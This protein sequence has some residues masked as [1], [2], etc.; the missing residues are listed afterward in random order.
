MRF[1]LYKDHAGDWRWRLRTT[2]GD[3]I[4]DSAE[5]YRHR[6]DCEHGIALV[7]GTTAETLVVDMSA[8]IAASDAGKPA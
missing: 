5:G 7:K 8:K 4:A 2:N 6:G 1:E 3:V